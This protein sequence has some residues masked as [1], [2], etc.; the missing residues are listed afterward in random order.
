M[1][2]SYQRLRRQNDGSVVIVQ[3][4]NDGVRRPARSA[5][6]GVMRHLARFEAGA[7]CPTDQ[8]GLC[9]ATHGHAA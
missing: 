7:A 4:P 3:V 2:S 9:A 1:A 5:R 6:T 8:T